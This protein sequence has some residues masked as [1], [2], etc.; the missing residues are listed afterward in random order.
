MILR[1]L[2]SS[3]ALLPALALAACTA[4]GPGSAPHPAT[5]A[6]RAAAKTAAQTEAVVHGY[7]QRAGLAGYE[8]FMA[9]AAGAVHGPISLCEWMESPVRPTLMLEVN[10]S[11]NRSLDINGKGLKN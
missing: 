5:P 8:R 10:N 3:I 2:P 6:A 11:K 1:R 7:S 9:S 4:G